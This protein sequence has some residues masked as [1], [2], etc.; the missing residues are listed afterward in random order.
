[1]VR[2]AKSDHTLFCNLLTYVRRFYPIQAA[3]GKSI[4]RSRDSRCHYPRY[5]PFVWGIHRWPVNSPHKGQWRG[6]LMFS[7]ICVWINSWVNKREAG[8]LRRNRAHYDAIAMQASMVIYNAMVVICPE[9][10]PSDWD[11][12]G[13]ISKAARHRWLFNIY[14]RLKVDEMIE[15]RFHVKLCL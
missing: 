10:C 3:E 12:N 6:T 15:Y 1:M 14:L 8:D 9:L 7:F 5:W 4:T 13:L 11:H 2:H